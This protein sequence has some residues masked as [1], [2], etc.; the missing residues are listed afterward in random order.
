[1]NELSL[2]VDQKAALSA[3]AEF[4]ADS[5][6]G[7]FV[8]SGAAGTG[9]TTL[10]RLLAESMLE[11]R[12]DIAYTALTGRAATVA[13]ARTR[14][15]FTTLHAFLYEFDESESVETE[16]GPRLAFKLRSNPLPNNYAVFVDEASMLGVGAENDGAMLQFGSGSP[17]R[18]LMERL[19]G[20]GLGAR[21]LILIGDQYQLPPVGSETSIV[22]AENEFKS[23][24]RSFTATPLSIKRS[25]LSTVH[26]QRKGSEILT[27][28]TKYRGRL[29]ENKFDRWIVPDAG[30]EVEVLNGSDPNARG[31][32]A[33][34]LASAGAEVIVIAH[35]NK[36]VA[37][38]N[39]VI[40]MKRWGSAA[41]PPRT[42]DRIMVV[43]K[44][45]S[46]ALL[47]GEICEIISMED[48]WHEINKKIRTS[49]QRGGG[50]SQEI[51]HKVRLQKCY[52]RPLSLPG[53]AES[54]AEA[55]SGSE[56][57]VTSWLL[58]DNLLLGKRDSSPEDVQ[59]LWVDFRVRHS[60]IKSGT[61]EYWEA[62]RND[63]F[64]N[65]VDARYGYAVTCHKAQGG[66]WPKAVVDLTS[67]T[68]EEKAQDGHRWA[69]TAITRAS[70]SLQILMSPEQSV[71]NL[72]AQLG[73]N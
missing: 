15:P 40:R 45:P 39:E 5:Q 66:Q 28:A 14:L 63:P 11:P 47:N 51:D 2:S 29:E 18:D 73:L 62:A 43:R 71:S 37:E 10:T 7:V 17:L 23:I 55:R 61:K 50:Y 30:N 60:R 12:A 59:A 69:Y 32:I 27:L 33:S 57:S 1:M 25:D 52:L 9:K 22:F 21:K 20:D 19:F 67:Y 13:Q 70:D 36:A 64:L 35:T 24:C 41:A 65:A 54:S 4:I 68:M 38:W 6:P 8:L 56:N 53:I 3:F 16:A 42:S 46:L 44:V 58:V 72:L 31:K 48:E 26:R 49:K 34:E